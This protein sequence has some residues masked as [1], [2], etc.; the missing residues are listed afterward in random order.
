VFFK[1]RFEYKSLYISRNVHP[2][3]VMIVLQNLITTPLYK[4]LN[5]TIH[6]Q[7]ASFFT[8]HMDSESH[9]LNCNDASFDNSN[10]NIEKL[11]CIPIDSMIY[12]FLEVPKIMDYEK[13]IYITL[14][15]LLPQVNIFTL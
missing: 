4:D 11:H 9:I 10:S 1:Q 12:N 6:H 2:N 14:Y 13:Y 8:L 5:V 15:I 3:M 7:W